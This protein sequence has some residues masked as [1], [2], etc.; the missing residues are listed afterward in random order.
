[1]ILQELFVNQEPPKHGCLSVDDYKNT[2]STGPYQAVTDCSERNYHFDYEQFNLQQELPCNQFMGFDANGQNGG[3]VPHY[4]DL[5]HFSD[6]NP[7]IAPPA[8][9]FLRPKCALWDCP[10]P[11]QGSDWSQDYCSPY[12]AYLASREGPPGMIPV[13]RPGGIDLKDGPLF[14]ALVARAQGKSV[15]IPE[16][17]G[18][19]TTKSP[20]NAPGMSCTN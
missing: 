10:R 4:Q 17:E 2:L 16:C 5:S 9:A 7:A 8:S 18:A 20:W 11:A 3:N 13:L 12:H 6:L 19:A 1:M 14:A 15:G